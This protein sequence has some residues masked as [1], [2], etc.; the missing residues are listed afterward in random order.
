MEKLFNKERLTFR[1][2]LLASEA[3]EVN[4]ETFNLFLGLAI[5]DV[6]VLRIIDDR[7]GITFVTLT[8]LAN[9]ERSRTSRIIQKLIKQNLIRR[10]NDAGDARRFQ[11]FATDAGAIMRKRADRLSDALEALLLAPLTAAETR[12]LNELLARLNGWIL[13]NDYRSQLDDFDKGT[14]SAPALE[15]TRPAPSSADAHSE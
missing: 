12:V 9:L 7:P 10:E 11:L 2:N 3:I 13:S 5:R 4:D 8:R 1:L 15:G 6:R 14:H